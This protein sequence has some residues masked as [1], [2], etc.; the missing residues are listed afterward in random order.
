VLGR[1]V[2]GAV[3]ERPEHPVPGG[4]PRVGDLLDLLLRPPPVRDQVGDG[5][6]GEGVLGAELLQVRH[7]HHG[8]VVVDQL[9]EHASRA[10]PGE[11]GQVDR[12]LGVPGPAQHPALPG[13]QRHHVSRPGQ[14]GRAGAGVGEQP[15]GVRPVGGRDAGADPLAGVHGHRV[16]GAPAVLVGVVHGRQVQPVA[17]GLG[18]R[19]ADVAGGPPDHER[20]QLRRRQFGGEDQVALVLPVGVVDHDDRAAGGDVRQSLLDAGKGGHATTSE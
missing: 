20:D 17:L 9:A 19:H 14:V 13:T 2:L 12:R 1:V 11:P 6:Q 3:A 7:P 16:G 8:A 10:S 5:D 18:Q 15:D 4:H